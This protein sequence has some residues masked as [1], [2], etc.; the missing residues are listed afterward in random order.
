MPADPPDTDPND[1]TPDERD[2]ERRTGSSETTLWLVMGGLLMLGGVVYVLS[3][4][5]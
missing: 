4:L 2:L 5:I 1:R 3:A